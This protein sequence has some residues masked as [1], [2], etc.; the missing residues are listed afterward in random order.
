[1]RAYWVCLRIGALCVAV[2]VSTSRAWSSP[3]GWYGYG[4]GAWSSTS[5][6]KTPD[7]AP[8]GTAF[9][10]L[11]LVADAAPGPTYNGSTTLESYWAPNTAGSIWLRVQI[12]SPT[13][14]PYSGGLNNAP[15]AILLGTG[16][17]GTGWLG[18]GA[19]FSSDITFDGNSTNPWP[20]AAFSPT[21]TSDRRPFP[22]A[23][24][25]LGMV[26]DSSDSTVWSNV[27]TPPAAAWSS[28]PTSIGWTPVSSTPLFGMYAVDPSANRELFFQSAFV[29]SGTTGGV[30]YNYQSSPPP[31]AST[32][33]GSAVTGDPWVLF[34]DLAL[35]S[36]V[37]YDVGSGTTYGVFDFMGN[38]TVPATSALWNSDQALA[39]PNT[40]FVLG[41]A[42]TFQ[43]AGRIVLGQLNVQSSNFRIQNAK[44]EALQGGPTIVAPNPPAPAKPI[45][46]IILWPQSRTTVGAGSELTTADNLEIWAR[47]T[48]A[49]LGTVT[50]SG[51]ALSCG[52]IAPGDG[53]TLGT[54]TLNGPLTL[55][56]AYGFSLQQSVIDV[57]VNP[58]AHA[59][60]TLTSTPTLGGQL[61]I[62]VSRSP[63][64]F[65][66][67]ER[68]TVL[69]APS[70]SGAFSSIQTPG[71]G[72]ISAFLSINLEITPTTYDMVVSRIRSYLDTACTENQ[73]RVA[74]ALDLS[75]T[76]GCQSP[77]LAVGL[78]QTIDQLSLAS[79]DCSCVWD[80]VSGLEILGM[81]QSGLTSA[82]Q[83]SR[84]TQWEVWRAQDG[85]T[86][87]PQELASVRAWADGS[88]GQST[89]SGGSA[90]EHLQ[91]QGGYGIVGIEGSSSDGWV[92]GA[93]AHYSPGRQNWD[94]LGSVGHLWLAGG[95]LY[96]AWSSPSQ[97]WIDGSTWYATGSAQIDAVGGSLERVPLFE[98]EP[99]GGSCSRCLRGS[100]SGWGAA[101]RLEGGY[102]WHAPVLLQP[103]L[104]LQGN[105]VRI[106]AFCEE[107]AP[108]DLPLRYRDN[109]S[110]LTW[111]SP[112]FRLSQFWESPNGHLVAP[113]LVVELN[114]AIGSRTERAWTGFEG[115]PFF[116]E[117]E[118]P[119][120]P[121]T[122]V[123]LSGGLQLVWNRSLSGQ[124]R[125]NLQK[126]A[127]FEASGVDV[128]VAVTF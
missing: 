18:V 29:P 110:S 125:A 122:T 41:T 31:A 4:R 33:F 24:M 47:A 107:G 114:Q 74:G 73:R 92:G 5:D 72:P 32:T 27:G 101:F 16:S 121:R 56:R 61:L 40:S 97:W 104:A 15:I 106:N 86:M 117:L 28:Q 50:A 99:F 10:N 64:F 53:Q 12:Q 7:D 95:G 77:A 115:S 14:S 109:S 105:W 11:Q 26:L 80:R 44:V 52:T 42:N 88:Y 113:E 8:Q 55:T 126:G 36:G 94:G 6:T 39:N 48:L 79:F 37:T 84:A 127:S 76:T 60:L 108:E 62:P 35:P 20:P 96:A 22:G 85:W 89:W 83:L 46:A 116:A 118:S 17:P 23:P 1:M 124:L 65:Q 81:L 63:G 112:G 51:G 67:G 57:P 45:A 103:Y 2:I 98:T 19:E 68:L 54:L 34:S 43:G 93:T 13:S 49:G 78:A 38:V 128:Q 58:T 9:E 66:E 123:F 75:R 82:S 102:R 71:A 59:R 87:R 100:P 21:A 91:T 3:Q 30:F 25:R 69:S 119:P 90:V 111:V 70:F 120:L